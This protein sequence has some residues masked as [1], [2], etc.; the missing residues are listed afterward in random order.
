MDLGRVKSSI[1]D[2]TIFKKIKKR[3]AIDINRAYLSEQSAIASFGSL[4]VCTAISSKPYAVIDVSNKLH[5]SG[6]SLDYITASILVDENSREIRVREIIEDLEKWCTYFNVTIANIDVQVSKNV[7]K[8]V[9]TVFGVASTKKEITKLDLTAHKSIAG[10]KIAVVNPIGLSGVRR[11]YNAKKDEI[12][13]RYTED[14]VG[15]ALG[16][17]I[18]LDASKTADFIYD[19]FRDNGINGSV[20]AVCE[21]GVLNSLWD[22]SIKGNAGFEIDIR[23]V[24]VRQEIIEI[25]EMYGI[26]PYELES[27]GTL[28]VTYFG[29][30][31]IVNILNEKN[32]TA[33]VIGEFVSSN[34]KIIRSL[35]EERFLEMPGQD[36]IYKVVI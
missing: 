23:K 36:E 15:R 13:N 1:F 25:C 2:R 3:G 7:N 34:N 26:N 17:D 12:L 28:L 35:S 21:C 14:V 10:A 33:N 30:C 6:A 8:P 22:Y 4:N 27:M 31:D 20:C 11:I 18:E 29:E 24:P 32:V 5:A 9:T 16:E 19:Y